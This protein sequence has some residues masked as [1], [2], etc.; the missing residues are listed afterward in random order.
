M[1]AY[2]ASARPLP[3]R[4]RCDDGTVK[5]ARPNT[6]YGM[7]ETCGIITANSAEF[8][9]DKPESGMWGGA[10]HDLKR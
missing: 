2:L 8:F 9:V 6:G 4:E 7:T 5:T 10:A 3:S 1:R